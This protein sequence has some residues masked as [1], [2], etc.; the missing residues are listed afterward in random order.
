MFS[1]FFVRIFVKMKIPLMANESH[2]GKNQENFG[3]FAKNTQ[4]FFRVCKICQLHPI[5]IAIV[6][7]G[8]IFFEAQ[9]PPSLHPIVLS[10]LCTNLPL[11]KN[12]FLFFWLTKY[13]IG[14]VLDVANILLK[15]E[16]SLK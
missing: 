3:N 7:D 11:Q 12:S 14:E 9:K 5:S 1:V 8:Y 16:R 13:Y 4:L 6:Y 2:K 10:Y 15:E